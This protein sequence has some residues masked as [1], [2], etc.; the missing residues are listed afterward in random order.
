MAAAPTVIPV[1][2]LRDNYGYIVFSPEADGD[3]VVV[4]ASEVAPVEQE[5][6][7]RGLR[8]RAILTTHHHWDHIGGNLHFSKA[9]AAQGYEL[10]IFGHAS[11]QARIPGLNRGLQDAECFEVAGL[12]FRALEVLGHTQ[13]GLVYCLDEL[14]F[15]GDTL[16]CGG[17]GRLKQGTAEQLHHSLTVTLAS[18]SDSMQLYCGHEYTLANL[19]FGAQYID[20]AA[21]RARHQEVRQRREQ[22]LFCGSSTW[23]L[24]R[25][26]NVFLRCHEAELQHRL[27]ASDELSCFTELRKRKDSA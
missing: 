12:R 5:L 16:F 11:E 10:P 17:C 26:T 4:D 19:D 23:G 6:E 7:R 2:C 14:C 13:G 18:L 22:G 1:P 24:E 8:L 9:C 27:Q 3:C 21:F 20:D 25:A 15:T